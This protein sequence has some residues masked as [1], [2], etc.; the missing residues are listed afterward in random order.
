MSCGAVSGEIPRDRGPSLNLDLKMASFSPQ[1]AI[2][3]AL[4]RLRQVAFVMEDREGQVPRGRLVEVR[5]EI[6]IG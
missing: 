5:N 2:T 3:P 6:S 4:T 1:S